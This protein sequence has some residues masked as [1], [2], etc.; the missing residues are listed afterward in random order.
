MGIKREV[1]M[2]IFEYNCEQC[3]KQF[4][5]LVFGKEEPECPECQSKQVCKLMSTCGFISKGSVG[6]P[7]KKSAGTS[8]CNSCSASS[9]TSCG[10]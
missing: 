6:T 2:P 5:Y 8:N 1:I 10:H 3:G 9:C 4:E 7:S